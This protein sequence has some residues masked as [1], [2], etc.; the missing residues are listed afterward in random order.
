LYSGG[1]QLEALSLDN[2]VL[3]I[4]DTAERREAIKAGTAKLVGTVPETIVAELAKL[5]D[6]AAYYN[7]MSI[8]NNPYGVV[9]ACAINCED[10]RK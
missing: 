5:L 10:L 1:V 2:P 4:R 6:D 7:Q 8:V 9:N 3:F